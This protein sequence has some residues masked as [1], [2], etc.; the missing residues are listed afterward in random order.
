MEEHSTDLGHHILLNNISILAKKPRHKGRLMGKVTK[1]K[2]HP[3][4]ISR[5]DRFSLNRSWRP[6]THSIKE[7]NK[8]LSKSKPVTS[9]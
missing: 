7:R 8:I 3:N 2:F 6:L 5:G 4:N 1:I 9:S